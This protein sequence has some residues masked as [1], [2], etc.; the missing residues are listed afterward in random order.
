MRVP[1]GPE[2]SAHLLV[3]ELPAADVAEVAGFPAETERADPD[4]QR[5]APAV[6]DA[7]FTVLNANPLA[8]RHEVR[9]GFRP[10][11]PAEHRPGRC[12]HHRSM[13]EHSGRVALVAMLGELRET[14]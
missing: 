4:S 2:R 3:R 12:G 7:A 10:L 6:A 9:Q 14:P 13:N 8:R 5:H 1:P 11:V